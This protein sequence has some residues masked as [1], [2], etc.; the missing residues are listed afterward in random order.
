MLL[1]L[2]EYK[3]SITHSLHR[4]ICSKS[5][6]LFGPLNPKRTFV[7]TNEDCSSIVPEWHSRGN[8]VHFAE[9]RK[10]IS[11]KDILEASGHKIEIAMEFP[12]QIR[13]KVNVWFRFTYQN[14]NC[15]QIFNR[16]WL[17]F[18]MRTICLKL[19]YMVIYL[20]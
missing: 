20:L 13:R 15:F 14:C 17:W 5:R 12:T 3:L 19:I 18:L 9:K 11:S 4:H 16:K 10:R 1:K 2:I 7:S 8:A 6:Y